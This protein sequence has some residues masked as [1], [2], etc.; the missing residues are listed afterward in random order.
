MGLMVQQLK[1][2]GNAC[3]E[4]GKLE[5][6]VQNYSKAIA[7]D[8]KNH[9]LFSNRRVT[10]G[11]H[12][13]GCRKVSAAY[14][15]LKKYD[16]ALEDAEITVR[17][18][19]DWPKG[20]SRKGTALL[21]LH[22]NQQASE[23]FQSGLALDPTNQQLKEGLT[24]CKRRVSAPS[25]PRMPSLSPFQDPAAFEELKTNPRTRDFMKDTDFAKTVE[26]IRKNPEL[27]REKMHDKRLL[28]CISVMMV[29]T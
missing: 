22:R 16:T 19:P 23:V 3:M 13:G 12:G 25:A 7:L 6:A 14:A 15:K 26:D 5:E 20:Y 10:G 21:Y 9:V 24:E 11:C 8:A 1:D 28:T 18:K 17:L 4:S 27:L 29:W 2:E